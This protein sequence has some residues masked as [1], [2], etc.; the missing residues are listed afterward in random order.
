METT[1]KAEAPSSSILQRCPKF[2]SQDKLLAWCMDSIWPTTLVYWTN[3]TASLEDPS[4]C[5]SGWC[6]LH[7]RLE[8]SFSP[9]GGV[10]KPS[11]SSNKNPTAI[12]YSWWWLLRMES[13]GLNGN[14][15]L[16]LSYLA[17]F[18]PKGG[19]EAVGWL[20]VV[21]RS[22]SKALVQHVGGKPR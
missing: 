1:I 2:R 7:Y 4:I 13:G 22:Y 10:P 21:Q 14:K 8:A 20:C 9:I 5:I 17:S 18:A 11:D 15:I 6:M 19:W 12:A 3:W 16:L